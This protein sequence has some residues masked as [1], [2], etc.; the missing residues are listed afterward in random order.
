MHSVLGARHRY[1]CGKDSEL[2]ATLAQ[3]KPKIIAYIPI[4]E[5]NARA[6]QLQDEDPATIGE[7]LRFVLYADEK[8]AQFLRTDEQQFV[9]GF[10]AKLE[11]FSNTLPFASVVRPGVS[12]RFQIN[13]PFRIGTAFSNCC[14]IG[15]AH[16]RQRADTI[17]RHHPLGLQVNLATGVANGLLVARTIDEC[18]E[19][20]RRILTRSMEFRI[21]ETKEMWYLHEVL[22]DSIFRV[23]TKQ[24]KV[25]NCFW[26]FY[27]QN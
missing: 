27:L 24:K 13:S 17:K 7:R 9:Q 15:A 2:A 11:E 5:E 14:A 25:S 3:G 1:S 4:I 6:R 22:T 16:L 23:V 8:F 20:L 21:V 26:N 18:A 12:K 19:L 10:R